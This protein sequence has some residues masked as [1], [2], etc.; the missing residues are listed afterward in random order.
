MSS[1]KKSRAYLT[2]FGAIGGT[3]IPILSTLFSRLILYIS[4]DLTVKAG[5]GIIY[6]FSTIPIEY[7]LVWGSLGI[8]LS[9]LPFLEWGSINIDGTSTKANKRKDQ[10]DKNLTKIF[11]AL[12]IKK[13]T[14]HGWKIKKIWEH[15]NKLF[16]RYELY[17]QL[18][19]FMWLLLYVVKLLYF[20]KPDSFDPAT[21]QGFQNRILLDFWC[22]VFN[23]LN[24]LA[25]FYCFYFLSFVK[26]LLGQG[27]RKLKV[28]S[29]T[30]AIAILSTLILIAI[31][32]DTYT[33]FNFNLDDVSQFTKAN[34]SLIRRH[35]VYLSA[36]SLLSGTILALLAVKLSSKFMRLS[37]WL[38]IS[39]IFY[40]VIQIAYPLQ[41]RDYFPNVI[42]TDYGELFD[43]LANI[44]LFIAFMGK[45]SL[46]MILYVIR[47]DYLLIH[48]FLRIKTL[49]IIA[50]KKIRQFGELIDDIRV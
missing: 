5:D 25:L 6:Y 26:P 9:M 27:H 49:D 33:R 15:C 7:A 42:S 2:L 13:K 12:G 46:I 4:N 10:R 8:I 39:L 16:E 31:N 23:I 37:K 24:T 21:T 41:Q 18:A 47:R 11:A 30:H 50:K 34:L 40:S 28:P 36:L 44:T 35:F 19:V 22:N 32:W 45:V 29:Y 1:R 3:A 38:I 43:V 14:H 20:M 17:F 48:Y